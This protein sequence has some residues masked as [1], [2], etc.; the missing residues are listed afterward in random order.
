MTRDD[1][2]KK[3]EI[4][5][6]LSEAMTSLTFKEREKQQDALHGVEWVM[7][8][9]GGFIENALH[10]LDALIRKRRKAGSAYEIAERMDPAY[11][12]ARSFRIMFLRGNRYDTQAAANQ[13]LKFFEMKQQLFGNDKLTRDIT[14]DDLDEDDIAC[15]K[16]GW[17]QHF[18]KDR[19]GRIVILQLLHLRAFKT[20]QNEM[21]VKFYMIMDLLQKDDETQL[22]G[23]CGLTYAV[24]D[25]TDVMKGAGYFEHVD[26]NNVTPCHIASVH[27][28]CSKVSEY[29]LCKLAIKAM[30]PKLRA[31]FRLHFGSHVEC[32]YSL[33][34]YGISNE[35]LPLIL[36]PDKVDT[37][38]PYAMKP[39][40]SNDLER[41]S[42]HLVSAKNPI[43][44]TE[45]T[46][47]DVLYMGGNKSDNAGNEHLRNLVA[48]WSH[49]Y[50][51]AM[52][53]GKRRVVD[54]IVDEIHRSGGRFLSQA[55]GAE[56]V[57]ATVPRTEV[58]S[59]I[60]QMFRNRR[61]KVRGTR[62]KKI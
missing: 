60:T 40:R 38:Q 53:I 48:E 58:R 13:M 25:C 21:R 3:H 36:G 59:K 30:S 7:H 43:V 26:L 33:A 49:T 16:T 29:L 23:L 27:F 57:W 41:S 11:V 1:K 46:A 18:G 56:S 37:R 44:V 28:C 19:S 42:P 62:K 2:Q 22:K 15:L 51:V 45:P 14:I 17:L 10:D 9:E 24:E 52:N 34:T 4:D 50:D 5:A 54:Q 35:N 12:H 39:V 32:Q 61:R 55:H 20:L 31:R 8:E 47:N 6:L